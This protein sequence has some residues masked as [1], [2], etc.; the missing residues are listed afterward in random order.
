MAHYAF[1]DSNNIVV[2]VIA[3]RDEDDLPHGISDWESYYATVRGLSCKRTSYHTYYAGETIY[4]D[5]G[6]AIGVTETNPQHSQGKTPFRGK[7][8]T[9]G[10]YYDAERDVFVSAPQE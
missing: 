5:N 6:E 2:E 3:G 7:F 1:L 9:I 4:D 10:D 8:A